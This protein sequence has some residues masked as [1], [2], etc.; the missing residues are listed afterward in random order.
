MR[1]KKPEDKKTP[2]EVLFEWIKEDR[3]IT[4]EY[5]RELSKM[6]LEVEKRVLAIEEILWAG[7]AGKE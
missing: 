4:D 7:K 6:I 2:L 5:M 3:D 1:S